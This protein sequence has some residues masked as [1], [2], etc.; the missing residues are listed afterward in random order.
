[1]HLSKNEYNLY[2]L[3]NKEIDVYN[4]YEKSKTA[5][6]DIYKIKEKVKR[7]KV[8]EWFI[9]WGGPNNCWCNGLY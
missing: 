1:M 6:I 9:F 8:Y 4:L 3:E 5:R 7:I 2:V